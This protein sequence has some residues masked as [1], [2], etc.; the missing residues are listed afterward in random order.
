MFPFS[1]QSREMAPPSFFQVSISL[2]HNSSFS[3]L[4]DLGGIL[5]GGPCSFRSIRFYSLPFACVRHCFWYPSLGFSAPCFAFCLL[6]LGSASESIIS[7]VQASSTII[8]LLL[9]SISVRYR[10]LTSPK[11]EFWSQEKGQ[12]NGG[13][14]NCLS[15]LRSGSD[16]DVTRPFVCMIWG[17]GVKRTRSFFPAFLVC[18]VTCAAFCELSSQ[19]HPFPPFFSL[20]LSSLHK[21]FCQ[22]HTCRI[23]FCS[24]FSFPLFFEGKLKNFELGYILFWGKKT[25]WGGKWGKGGGVYIH[26]HIHHGRHLPIYTPMPSSSSVY[27]MDDR[28][29]LGS[30]SESLRLLLYVLYIHHILSY[31]AHRSISKLA[32]WM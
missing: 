28:W 10:D 32:C 3:V 25:C 17:W 26:R 29:Y 8:L 4:G 2:V 31:I 13:R 1:T 12:S 20:P 18:V 14:G 5:H 19:I 11:G 7:T 27:M 9:L 24:F 22:V 16:C 15:H 21:P 6:N 30:S 23:L